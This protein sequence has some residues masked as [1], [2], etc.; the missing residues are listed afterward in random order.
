MQKPLIIRTVGLSCLLAV[1][2][3]TG[4]A[5][6][7]AAG[8]DNR[9]MDRQS[10]WSHDGRTDELD[11]GSSGVHY[12]ELDNGISARIY[13]ANCLL[14]RVVEGSSGWEIRLENG[15]FLSLITDIN[16]PLISN[17]G[18]GRFHPFQEEYVE[19]ALGEI[20]Y[21]GLKLNIDV[22]ILPFPRRSI[23]ASSASGNQIF[24]SPQ[25]RELSYAG[26]AYI[27]THELGHVFQ[28]AYLPESNGMLWDE[29]RK[30][31]GIGDEAVFCSSAG[32]DFRPKEIFAEDFRVLFGG[33]AARYDGSVQNP[34]L[35]SPLTVS[36]LREF[37]L[38]LNQKQNESLAI[39]SL[40]NHPNP[41]NPETAIQIVLSDEFLYSHEG[42]MVRV[43][44]VTGAFVREL[45]SGVPQ[46]KNMNIYWDGKNSNGQNV[47]SSTYFCV[48]KAGNYK[49]TRK[50]LLLK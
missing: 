36:G 11:D 21:P 33:E 5:Q 42:L 8:V 38:S 19:K 40:S 3:L 23:P 39:S 43:Y 6:N 18:D 1:F 31:R 4:T 27:T 20:S 28:Y 24:L 30:I 44:D 26:A 14:E 9:A 46:D 16:D 47:A 10:F 32:H 13:S 35:P 7:S 37:F 22:Y 48:V 29:Y 34:E 2:L 25:V 50:M 15:R 49:M 17:R 45:F 41:F 12:I